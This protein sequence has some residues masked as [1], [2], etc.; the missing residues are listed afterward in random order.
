M[1]HTERLCN[2]VA[3]R[4]I[5]APIPGELRPVHSE[6]AQLAILEE[7]RAQLQLREQVRLE[8]MKEDDYW[9]SV[10]RD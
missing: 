8:Q 9:A 3:A 10:L 2:R 1:L 6:I 4:A 5:A 7:R